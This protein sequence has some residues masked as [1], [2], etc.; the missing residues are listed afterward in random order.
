MYTAEGD[1]SVLQTA[2]LYLLYTWHN[3]QVFYFQNH[4]W[5]KDKKYTL[6]SNAEGDL[7]VLQTA[8]YLFIKT[9]DFIVKFTYS[10]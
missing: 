2:L 7:A 9:I 6:M 8:L 1:L 5:L 3:S 4:V 10:I